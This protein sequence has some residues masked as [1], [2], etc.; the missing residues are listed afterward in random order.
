MRLSI[1]NKFFILTGVLF[2][3]VV[4]IY[5]MLATLVFRK[6]K[7]SF[8]ND[9]NHN[10]V[11]NTS[12]QIRSALEQVRDRVSL[13]VLALVQNNSGTRLAVNHV[14]DDR[15][16]GIQ[17]FKK[18]PGGFVPDKPES[19]TP[20]IPLE[21]ANNF[22]SEAESGGL[23]FWS[24][25]QGGVKQFFMASKVDLELAGQNATYVALAQIDPRTI[26]ETLQRA[27][28]FGLFLAKRTGEL[29]L[30]LDRESLA[31][32]G[33]N[34]K[35]HP[36][37]TRVANDTKAT[38]GLLSYDHRGS[39][40]YGA[41]AS[42]GLGNLFLVS[43]ASQLEAESGIANLIKSSAMYAVIVI[44]LCFLVVYTF[45]S[46]FTRRFKLFEMAMHKIQ[47]GDLE[48][49]IHIRSGDEMES[50]ANS[51]NQMAESLRANALKEKIN[52]P[53]PALTEVE[54]FVD[55]VAK[56][57]EKAKKPIVAFK[58]PLPQPPIPAKK[59]I[60]STEEE[61]TREAT[62]PFQEAQEEVAE[63]PKKNAVIV[64]DDDF[65]PLD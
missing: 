35:N 18:V 4:A 27:N 51:F 16:L 52:A 11:V 12:S 56:K 3:G 50:L 49:K 42:L 48:T 5:T 44:T 58:S 15:I 20:M 8:F 1:S 2:V 24:M 29:I 39:K 63:K 28:L 23:A 59:A 22:L 30:Q 43:Q 54:D 65:R 21:A 14:K 62:A 38:S 32:D 61:V 31:E 13:A 17:L 64:D 34:V 57:A 60:Q 26:L 33:N 41:Y 40:W 7:I 37:I 36:V 47:H 25:Q 10:V 46:R 6:D 9:V 55:T 19:A 45:T 53:Q